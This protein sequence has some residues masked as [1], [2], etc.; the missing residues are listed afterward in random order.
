VAAKPLSRADCIDLALHSAPN[1]AAWKARI[2]SAKANLAQAGRLP[3]P[4]IALGWED[5][6]LNAA[7]AGHAVQTT[8]SLAMAL[9]DLFARERREKAAKHEWLAEEAT[10]RAEIAVTS[11]EVARDYDRLV[12]AR[13]RAALSRELAQ[14]AEHQC[15][16]MDQ[17]VAAGVLAAIERKRAE[18][19]LVQARGEAATKEA[20]ARALELGFAFALGFERPVELSLE[21]TLTRAD[22]AADLDLE[23]LLTR[24]IQ[25][26]PELKAASESYAAELE[27]LRLRASRVN[28][29]PTIGGG[30]RTEG[31]ELRGVASIEAE[32]P[33]F[34]SG[35]AAEA[36][37]DA[38]LLAAAAHARSAAQE[39][40]REVCTAADRRR[41]AALFLDSHAR[42]LSLRRRR[43]R[44]DSERL[45]SAGELDYLALVQARRDEVE[46]R[47]LELDAELSLAL[48]QIDLDKA[49]GD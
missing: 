10:L 26:R 9:G 42:E 35:S 40:A 1:R 14:V 44:E 17:F 13:A 3:N 36:S 29:L 2:D 48:A 4:T 16:A 37:A 43:L 8:L 15:A 5:F 20:E 7:A 18:A 6:G 12:A 49:L 30:V 22:R 46:A 38:A 23:K 47:E 27:R 24:A 21:D 31:N 28:F 11:G 32:L 45:F 25:Q 33:I 39:V 19:E 41:A 34:D